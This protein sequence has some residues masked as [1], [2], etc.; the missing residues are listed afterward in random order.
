MMDQSEIRPSRVSKISKQA[1]RAVLA[2]AGDSFRDYEDSL[3]FEEL[4]ILSLSSTRRG[5]VANVVCRRLLNIT[6]MV[7]CDAECDILTVVEFEERAQRKF[8]LRE[9]LNRTNEPTTITK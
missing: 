7:I 4:S 9:F 8:P 5:W 6:F 2:F 3:S 1:K